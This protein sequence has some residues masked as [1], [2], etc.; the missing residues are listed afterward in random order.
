MKL[1]LRFARVSDDE[2]RSHGDARHLVSRMVDEAPGHVDVARPVHGSEHRAVRVLDRHI[3]IWQEHVVVRHDVHHAQRQ[4][5]GVD[6]EHAQPGEIRHLLDDHLEQL[7]QAVL[8]AEVGAIPNRVLR[9]EHDFFGAAGDQIDDLLDDMEWPFAD[10]SALDRRDRAEGA[11]VI[12]TIGD[13]DVRGGSGLVTAKRGKH[14]FAACGLG[15]HMLAEQ[16]G[17]DVANLEPL[18]RRQNVVDPVRYVSPV[19]AQRRHATGGDDALTFTS[20]L[21]H[22]LEDADRF[23]PRGAQKSARVD[24]DDI[25][26]F[27]AAGYSQAPLPQQM[28]HAVGI[29]SILG[30]PQRDDVK[31]PPGGR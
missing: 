3:Q 18:A 25:R 31:G 27:G 16:A 29:D 9:D 19:I 4:W 23:C 26:A 5:A 14:A 21:K 8:H 13:L 2:R 1:S 20:T 10:L 7:G 15:R 30:A 6:I 22:L 11:I 24:D 17:H 28:I 12:T